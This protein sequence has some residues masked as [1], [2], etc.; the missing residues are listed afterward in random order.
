M[1]VP[2]I[3]ALRYRSSSPGPGRAQRVLD[4]DAGGR[5]D[6]PAGADRRTLSNREHREL[7][8][9]ESVCAM[10]ESDLSFGRPR[11]RQHAT[12]RN[13]IRRSSA[14]DDHCHMRG[15]GPRPAGR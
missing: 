10:G 9:C 13:R 7:M 8:V 14:S 12:S 4:A 2:S 5:I 11:M 3:I 1:T 15:P 6:P